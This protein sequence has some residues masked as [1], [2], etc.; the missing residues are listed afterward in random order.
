M[1]YNRPGCKMSETL[2]T[3]EDFRNAWKCVVLKATEDGSTY[4]DIPLLAITSKRMEEELAEN[5]HVHEINGYTLSVRNSDY[6]LEAKKNIADD[7]DYI[8][9]LWLQFL[10]MDRTDFDPSIVDKLNME[11]NLG[12][13]REVFGKNADELFTALGINYEMMEWLLNKEDTSEYFYDEEETFWYVSYLQDCKTANDGEKKYSFAL[14]LSYSSLTIE[15]RI[16]IGFDLDHVKTIE[17]SIGETPA[18]QIE[19]RAKDYD[20]WLK[21]DA[22]NN[23]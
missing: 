8:R 19:R 17:Y 16:Y 1:E 14:S 20:D 9:S 11:T 10:K 6:V 22:A 23:Q 15:E 3:N 5:G 21:E 2:K 4:N 7:K 13:S 12:I 18:D